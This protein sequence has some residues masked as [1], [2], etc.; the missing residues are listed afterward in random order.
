MEIFSLQFLIR[1]KY[2][3]QAKGVVFERNSIALGNDKYWSKDV[4]LLEIPK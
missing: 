2:S 3:E 1:N 4:Y